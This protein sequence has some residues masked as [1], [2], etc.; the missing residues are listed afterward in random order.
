LPGQFANFFN[1]MGR[2]QFEENPNYTEYTLMFRELFASEEFEYDYCYDWTEKMTRN[3]GQRAE[4]GLT[5]ALQMVK[6]GRLM[7]P[8]LLEH[9]RARARV[10]GVRLGRERTLAQR[11][12]G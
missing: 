3:S 9:V 1:A 8:G 6:S 10:V 7:K 2:L 4:G 11:S 5:V 12:W